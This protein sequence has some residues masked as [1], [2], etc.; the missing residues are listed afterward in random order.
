MSVKAF[1]LLSPDVFDILAQYLEGKDVAMLLTTGN[2]FLINSIQNRGS[3]SS[4]KAT[5]TR[6]PSKWPEFFGRQHR[7]RH[8]N[9]QYGY[10]CTPAATWIFSSQT[11]QSLPKTLISIHLGLITAESAW[12]APDRSF[13]FVISDLFPFLQS[14]SLCGKQAWTSKVLKDLPASLLVLRL[15]NN[16]LILSASLADLPRE[17][18]EL[19]LPNARGVWCDNLDELLPPKL[20]T[21]GICVQK[22]TT[23][24]ILRLRRLALLRTLSLTFPPG[25]GRGFFH[26]ELT[27]IYAVVSELPST[28]TS[29]TVGSCNGKEEAQFA[30]S[31]FVGTPGS[32]EAL[33][34]L[35]LK[36]L[37]MRDYLA[38]SLP[39]R[40][41]D[42]P[43]NLTRLEISP[44]FSAFNSGFHIPEQNR[45]PR[46]ATTQWGHTIQDS[47]QALPKTITHLDLASPRIQLPLSDFRYLPPN[48]TFLQLCMPKGL[49]EAD[50]LQCLPKGL[51]LLYV[52]GLR[53]RAHHL[54]L[55]PPSINEISLFE[56]ELDDEFVLDLFNRQLDIFKRQKNHFSIFSNRNLIAAASN[57]LPTAYHTWKPLPWR[58]SFTS[59][60]LSHLPESITEL[61]GLESIQPGNQQPELTLLAPQLKAIH[62]AKAAYFWPSEEGATLQWP[63][64]LTILDLPLDYSIP[65][66]QITLLPRTLTIL[67]LPW[68]ESITNE[69][70]KDLPPGLVHLDLSYNKLITDEAIARL[71]RSLLRLSLWNNPLLTGECFQH[72]PRGLIELGMSRAKISGIHFA[73]LPPHL[74]V[75]DL[76]NGRKVAT[77]DYTV[78]PKS[79]RSINWDW[80]WERYK[81]CKAHLPNLIVS[82]VILRSFAN[83]PTDDK[84]KAF[85][86]DRTEN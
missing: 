17:M 73:H 51:R 68:N 7:L 14:I 59:E 72:L 64:E 11:L 1:A 4:I 48:L 33:L 10:G 3:L 23:E 81:P 70:V 19:V 43:P 37:V 85:W 30:G 38:S 83:K 49:R 25:L 60:V 56:I 63:P 62:L 9:V 16:N 79:L 28:L 50:L 20:H 15:Y 65:E 22:A 54:L 53:L 76:G 21:L 39:F 26:F 8:L 13:A 78:L 82:S 74:E 44:N 6:D 41:K 52:Q 40:F 77:F 61:D 80:D 18:E 27:E 35:H 45:L 55:L 32:L 47:L 31:I 69:E 24:S 2:R 86:E 42:L 58:C 67:K 46:I 57:L 29:L 75:L 84:D 66:Y 12:L 36:S 34:P 5:F 71:P